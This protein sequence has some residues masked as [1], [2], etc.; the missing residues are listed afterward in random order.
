MKALRNPIKTSNKTWT[1]EMIDD[2]RKML[3]E[4]TGFTESFQSCNNYNNRNLPLAEIVK[5][6]Y[7]I[8]IPKITTPLPKPTDN[9][10]DVNS[11]AITL[12]VWF[13]SHVVCLVAVTILT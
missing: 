8:P 3:D 2:Y 9:C 12:S 11:S 6:K 4:Q 1:K 7:Q 13:L 5:D 10:K